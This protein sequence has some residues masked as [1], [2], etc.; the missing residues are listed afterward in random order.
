MFIWAGMLLGFA[1]VSLRPLCQSLLA[2]S[3]WILA[4]TMCSYLNVTWGMQQDPSWTP[5]MLGMARLCTQVRSVVQSTMLLG[6]QV[7]IEKVLYWGLELKV[8]STP[9]LASLGASRP[10]MMVKDMAKC[11]GL[12]PASS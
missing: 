5:G 8:V 12:N 3:D 6:R 1:L 10:E 9:Y 11:C 4:R 7:S 2:H